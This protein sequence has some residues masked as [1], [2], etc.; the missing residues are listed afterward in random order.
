MKTDKHVE[1]KF[2]ARSE[3]LKILNKTKTELSSMIT[4]SADS[5]DL[6]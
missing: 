1:D 4:Q 5:K 2:A 6:G 3:P